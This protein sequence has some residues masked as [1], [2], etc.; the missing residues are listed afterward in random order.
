MYV[1]VEHTV[2]DPQTFGEI[3]QAAEIPGHLTLHQSL[4][5]GDGTQAVCLWEGPSVDAV[6]SYV[7]DGV[8]HVSRN[9]YFAVD[10]EKAMGLPVAAG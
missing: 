3:T 2:N 6:R 8:G 4:P 10:T 1:I 9:V 7:E 5:K